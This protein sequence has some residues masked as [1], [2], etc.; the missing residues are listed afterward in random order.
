ML[1]RIFFVKKKKT[2]LYIRVYT[3]LLY[4]G[5]SY[6]VQAE[7][8]PSGVIETPTR[9]DSWGDHHPVLG[10]GTPGTLRALTDT[11]YNNGIQVKTKHENMTLCDR[12]LH[13]FFTWS[14]L[15]VSYNSHKCYVWSLAGIEYK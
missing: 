1:L 15:I 6:T 3:W 14:V 8:F 11:V 2:W 10:P 7:I 4:I 12:F 5:L 9:C 13:C